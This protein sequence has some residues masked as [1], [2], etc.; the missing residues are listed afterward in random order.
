[1]SLF[2]VTGLSFMG[3]R[4]GPGYEGSSRPDV[5][6]PEL[7]MTGGEVAHERDAFVVLEDLDHD[8]AGPQQCLLPLKG[9]VLADDHPGNAVQQDRA[10]T[11]RARRERGV[12]RALAI[13]ARRL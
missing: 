10:R 4:G 2:D 1:M 8:A 13:Y 11:H 7:G 9:L 3:S 5:L 6:V 12:Q